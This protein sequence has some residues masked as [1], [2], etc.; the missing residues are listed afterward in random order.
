MEASIVLDQPGNISLT[1]LDQISGRVV[2]RAS[3]NAD[4][5]SILVKLEGE[6]RTRLVPPIGP[7]GEHSRP[8]MEYHK[9]RDRP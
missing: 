7:N 3:R 6:S 8:Q 9:V 1:N 2:V 4:I 5:D